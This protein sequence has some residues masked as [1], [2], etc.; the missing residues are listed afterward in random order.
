MGLPNKGHFATAKIIEQ[1]PKQPG[2]P[3][4]VSLAEDPNTIDNFAKIIELVEGMLAYERAG[5]D[6]IE[7]NFSCPNVNNH[8]NQCGALVEMQKYGNIDEVTVTNLALLAERFLNK[9]T[10]NIPVIAK[11]SNDIAE[12]DIP[13][14]IDLLIDLQFDGINIGNTTVKYSNY[15]PALHPADVP[16]FQRFIKMFGGGLSGNVLKSNSLHK[17]QIAS[18]HI[19]KKSLQKEFIVIRT[20]GIEDKNDIIASQNVGIKMNQ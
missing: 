14:L 16:S 15:M 5:A 1:I 6:F 11:Y 8:A 18:Q 12:N 17:C 20:G 7:I 3:I 9:R 10:R 19:N 2:C 13:P 4:G